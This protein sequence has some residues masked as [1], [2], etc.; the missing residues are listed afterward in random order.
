MGV[1]G[2]LIIQQ[3]LNEYTSCEISVLEA[4]GTGLGTRRRRMNT[5][6]MEMMKIIMQVWSLRPRVQYLLLRRTL[7]SF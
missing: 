1:K 7:F 2:N 6:S 3:T 4:V 5:V